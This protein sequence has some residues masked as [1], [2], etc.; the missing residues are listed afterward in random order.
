MHFS[1]TSKTCILK[2]SVFTLSE[3][4]NEMF[5]KFSESLNK[6]CH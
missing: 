3:E 1:P 4:K 6:A 5:R 2:E